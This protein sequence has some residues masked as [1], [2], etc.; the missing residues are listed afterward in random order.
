MS[1]PAILLLEDG[2][3][4]AGE[5]VG[6]ERIATGEVVFNTSMMG[7]QEVLTDPSYAGQIVTM[8]YP[9]IGNYGVT[10]EDEESPHPQVA[11]FVVREMARVHSGWRAEGSLP[12][13]LERNG[14][15]AISEVDTRALTR[16]I[17][18][19]GAMRGA[20]APAGVSRDDVMAMIQAHPRMENLDLTGDV[21]TTREY[22]VPA[23]GIERF[24][25]VAYDFGVKAHS[26]R[27][28]ADRGCRVTV[29]PAA[30]PL[31]SVLER[32]PDGLFL[33]NGPGDP[34]AVE[35]ALR[36]IR[37]AG[38]EGMPIFGICLGHQL[39]ARAYG[40]RTY[41]LLYGHRGGNHPVRRLDTG[42]VEI[43]AQNHGFAVRGGEGDEVPDAPAVRLTHVNLND[44]TVEGIEHRELPIF[45]VQ[46]HPE[47]APGPHDSRYLFDRFV[48]RMEERP[49]AVTQKP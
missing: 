24:H 8:T 26:P 6:A 36:A 47:S 43:T 21:T 15:V 2:R 10:R 35:P 48:S 37:A 46:Y 29:V 17:R 32:E 22:V 42:E 14:I 5:A 13:Y 41:K 20:I 40:A 49:A 16:H 25:V 11:G 4:F 45:S 33:S 18:S 3:A 30:T 28:L 31:E 27:L 12:A 1:N 39:V 19:A 44:G 7:Y 23:V 38:D 9:L 34:Q